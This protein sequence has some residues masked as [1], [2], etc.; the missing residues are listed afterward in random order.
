MMS[1]SYFPQT[2]P[3]WTLTRGV[4]TRRF[5]ALIVDCILVSMLGWALAFVIA[6]LGIFTFGLGWLAFHILPWL[7]IL[8]LTLCIGGS[9]AT[10]GQRAFGLAVRQDLGLAPPNMAQALVWSLLLWLSFVLACIPFALAL[11]GPRHRAAHDVLAG[12]V[13]I[14]HPQNSY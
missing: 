11:I 8:Y 10:P 4:L 9:G 2:Q 13:V 5:L 14:R 1:Q 3:D 12:L 6:I 7:P